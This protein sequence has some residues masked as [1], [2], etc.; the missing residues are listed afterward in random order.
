MNTTSANSMM[1][2]NTVA[3]NGDSLYLESRMLMRN[4]KANG[5]DNIRRPIS[6]ENKVKVLTSNNDS[7]IQE[8]LP[9]VQKQ[10]NT[11]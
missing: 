1:N 3:N 2:S 11:L 4:T 7:Q 6:Y 9:N 10:I 8:L 5:F